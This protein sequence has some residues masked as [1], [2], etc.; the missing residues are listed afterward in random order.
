M[1]LRLLIQYAEADRHFYVDISSLALLNPLC[2]NVYKMGSSII[3]D[4]SRQ[5]ILICWPSRFEVPTH[6]GSQKVHGSGNWIDAAN[7]TFIGLG[8]YY[9]PLRRYE[10]IT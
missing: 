10:G 2:T 8:L 1:N 4:S 5:D 3:L 9:Y 6:N 7:R